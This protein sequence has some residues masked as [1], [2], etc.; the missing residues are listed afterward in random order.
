M[1]EKVGE[2]AQKELARLERM[3]PSSAEYTVS[4]TY[5]DYLTACPGTSKRTITWT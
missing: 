4:R 5:L 3:N 1:P 2:I